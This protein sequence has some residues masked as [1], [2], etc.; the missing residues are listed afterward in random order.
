MQ[1]VRVNNLFR[2][3]MYTAAFSGVL[4]VA[5]CSPI[6]EDNLPTTTPT[7]ARQIG[8]SVNDYYY[9]LDGNRVQLTPSFDWVVV[10]FTS[11]VSSMREEVLR[12]YESMVGP[13]EQARDIP[14]PS[15]TLLPLRAGITPHAFAELMDTMRKDKTSFLQVNPLFHTEDSEMAV[16][17]EFIATFSPSKSQAEI[18][19]ANSM[20]AVEIVQ[21]ILGQE[22]TFVLRVTGASDLDT[23]SMANLYQENGIAIYAAPN[24]IRI[25]K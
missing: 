25:K 17:D 22:N 18:D 21:P 7:E 9:Y 5:G 12:S 20:H 10:K 3:L 19:E 16:S 15:V 13:L 4:F 23:L 24:F 1:G 2:R 6:V 11:D 14:A 8:S